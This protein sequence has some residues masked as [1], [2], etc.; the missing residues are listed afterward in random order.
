M[1][2]IDKT[3]VMIVNEIKKDDRNNKEIK[4]KD[5]TRNGGILEQ[6]K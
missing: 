4:C 6:G 3:K 2:N 1:I 5:N